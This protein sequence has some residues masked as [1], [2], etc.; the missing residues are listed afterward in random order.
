MENLQ[1]KGNKESQINKSYT[2]GLNQETDNEINYNEMDPVEFIN[3]RYKE[4][5]L[6]ELNDELAA[7][8]K[9]ISSSKKELKLL[10]PKN[11]SNFIHC[12]SLLD[13]I[14]KNFQ[15]KSVCEQK[16][17]DEYYGML[18]NKFDCFMQDSS[19]K[20]DT[21]KE[22][23]IIQYKTQYAKLFNLKSN[24]RQNLLNFGAFI[25]TLK[26]AREMF[27]EV[28]EMSFFQ[29][30][31]NDAQHE[32]KEFLQNIYEFIIDKR[33]TFEECCVLFEYY[34][35][36]SGKTLSPNNLDSKIMNTLLVHF[37]EV[38]FNKKEK[39]EEYFAYLNQSLYKLIKYISDEQAIE[40]IRHY[41]KCI[42]DIIELT[43]P[44]YARKEIRRIADFQKNLKTKPYCLKEFKDSILDFK[45]GLFETFVEGKNLSEVSRIFDVFI[46]VIKDDGIKRIQEIILKKIEQHLT[47]SKL[48]GTEYL[49]QEADEISLVRP[50]LGVKG[51]KNIR[52]LDK[53]LAEKRNKAIDEASEEFLGLF[54]EYDDTGILMRALELSVKIPEYCS[55]V[56]V[57]CRDEIAKRPIVAYYLHE[58]LGTEIPVLEKE[59]ILQIKEMN[60]Q[61]GELVKK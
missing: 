27:E 59:D 16:E 25:K 10:V 4:F 17:I 12:R 14:K 43:S 13:K 9:S 50:C 33:T 51:S 6:F 19:L 34:F 57:K 36:A 46:S 31:M 47:S 15:Q 38:T 41:F 58:F 56:F 23:L 20:L 1:A 39:S 49:S 8:S 7:L 54:Q 5:S 18:F 22:N 3:K 48:S 52:S 28:K 37:K 55:K 32:I 24:L 30:K 29:Q 53:S 2:K 42:K 45:V 21:P 44:E 61:F 35:E 26:E 60:C 11:F 40:G